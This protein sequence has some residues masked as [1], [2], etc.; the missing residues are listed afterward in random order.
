MLKWKDEYE[1]YIKKNM[2]M[3]YMNMKCISWNM[4]KKNIKVPSYI[5]II[6]LIAELDTMYMSQFVT[7]MKM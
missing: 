7:E 1:I 2:Y 5:P 6:I 4:I 3:K